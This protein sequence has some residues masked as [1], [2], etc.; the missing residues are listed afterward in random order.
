MLNVISSCKPD[1]SIILGDFNARS[2]SWWQNDINTSEGTKIDALTSYHGLHQLISQPTHILANSSSC[3]DLIFTDQ[4]NLVIDC[5]TH[6]SLHLTVIIKL[7][8]VS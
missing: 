6:P 5:G 4:P 1:F 3:I 8:I 7:F 2:K